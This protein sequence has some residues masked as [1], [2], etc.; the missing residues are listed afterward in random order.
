MDRYSAS[1]ALALVIL[2]SGGCA[3][4]SS[5]ECAS[6]D[7]TAVGFEDGARGYTSDHFSNHRKACAKHGITAD[8]GAY[9]QGRTSGLVEFCQPG[10]GYNYGANGGRYNGVCA[11]DL[12]PEFLDAYRAGQRLYTLRA[13]VNSANSQIYNK[14]RELEGIAVAV[15]DKEALLIAADTSTEDR[16]LLLADLKRLSER[17]GELEV[18]I[19]TLIADRAR[20]EQ[21]LRQYEQTVATYDY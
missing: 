21:E 20:Y 3:S 18:E 10:R 7:W 16:V 6:S 14:Q 9:Q 12:E 1:L 2:V 4:M 19:D 13:N 8:F 15:R 17:S 11:A 5:D